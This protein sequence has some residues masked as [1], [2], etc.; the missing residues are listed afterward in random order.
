MHSVTLLQ[1]LYSVL[2][3]KRRDDRGG[4]RRVE[5]MQSAHVAVNMGPFQFHLSINVPSL[6][7]N[8]GAGTNNKNIIFE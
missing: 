7:M 1:R 3:V 4:L 8:N 6:V 2:G 5:A